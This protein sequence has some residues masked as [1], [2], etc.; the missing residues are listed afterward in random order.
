MNKITIEAKLIQILETTILTSLGELNLV[1]EGG[2][3]G[4]FECLLRD[5]GNIFLSEVAEVL[6]TATSEKIEDKLRVSATSQG[7]GKFEKRMLNIRIFTGQIIRIPNL[8]AKKVPR[9]YT[10]KRHLLGL[11]LGVQKRCSPT[12]VSMIC[13][14]SILSPS[15]EIA[16]Q[17]L[18]I[19][20]ISY[21]SESI[22]KLVLYVSNLSKRS[23]SALTKKD[24]EIFSGKRIL[25][26]MDGGRT[27][28]REN[29]GY[30][31]ES[32]NEV[33]STPW[34]EPKMF[35]LTEIDEFGKTINEHVIYGTMFGVDDIFE[36]LKSHL[37]GLE[38][39]SAKQIQIIADGAIWIWNRTKELL[40]S[41]NV[42]EEKIVET[43]DYYH[44]VEHIY[45][46]VNAIPKQKM[47]KIKKT[48]LVS[49]LKN[50]LWSG[51]TDKIVETFNTLFSKKSKEV[52]RDI[53]YFEKNKHRMQYAD[54][55]DN[56]LLVGSGIM[57]SG[58]RRVINLRF[59]NTSS[60][61]N[62]DNVEGLFF[63]RSTFLSGRW[64]NFINKFI[65]L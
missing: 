38:I 28:C 49:E 35:V 45:D 6:L 9:S 3:L 61:W 40:L 39:W 24:G 18:D 27:R 11:Y 60:F 5:L 1:S 51:N 34:K 57:E 4:K 43:I 25:I 21:D 53:N 56:K 10:G 46:L 31:N 22:R 62:Q 65:A 50:L 20:G 42:S 54:F 59:K 13:S 41:L 23:Q 19:Q 32:G 37:V 47:K 44:A 15:F 2:D 63:L 16:H 52:K 64:N 36:L 17:L 55:Q 12:Y 58:I 29:K 30:K 26:S 8:Y 14:V 33:Y 48:S 7:L